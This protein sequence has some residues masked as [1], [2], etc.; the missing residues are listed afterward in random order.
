MQGKFRLTWLAINHKIEITASKSAE[1]IRCA[2]KNH[3]FYFI[4]RIQK[5][6][7]I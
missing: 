5:M 1:K 3:E 4:A 2:K 7:A 6:R